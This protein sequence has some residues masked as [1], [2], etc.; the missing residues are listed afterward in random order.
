MQAFFRSSATLRWGGAEALLAMIVLAVT[1]RVMVSA[2][3]WVAAW[4]GVGSTGNT[5]V[6]LTVHPD[7][8]PWTLEFAPPPPWLLE[9][10]GS[11]RAVHCQIQPRGVWLGER[12]SMARACSVT[13]SERTLTRHD[14]GSQESK[15]RCMRSSIDV[16]IGVTPL[17]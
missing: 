11:T 6:R 7:V 14:E 9:L 17:T 4:M 10:L 13:V 15:G 2:A 5:L 16:L 8:P 1:I 12:V 3:R